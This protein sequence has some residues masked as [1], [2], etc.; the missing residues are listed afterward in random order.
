MVWKIEFQPDAERDLSLIFDHLFQTYQD[1]GEE[2]EVAFDRAA[3]RILGIR[4][5]AIDL[6]SNPHRGTRQEDYGANVRNITLNQA[7]IWF[8]I[9][10]EAETVRVLAFF[11]G[12]QDHLRHMLLRLLDEGS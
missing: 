10:E 11:F 6:A 1:L 7:I 4:D 3:A 5:S 8:N 12:G 9:E 2:P